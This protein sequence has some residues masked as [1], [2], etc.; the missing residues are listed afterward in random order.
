MKRTKTKTDEHLSARQGETKKEI[1]NYSE[2]WKE[3]IH[4]CPL[5]PLVL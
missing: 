5:T 4:T 1:A 3:K 2:N